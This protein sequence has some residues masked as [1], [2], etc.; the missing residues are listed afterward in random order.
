MG[1][2][3]EKQ[4]NGDYIVHTVWNKREQQ[5]NWD[6]THT[7]GNKREQQGNGDYTQWEITQKSREMRVP[8][9]SNLIDFTLRS[10]FHRF[11]C[12]SNGRF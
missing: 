8:R 5:G 2:N 4:G 11:Y 7:V 1:N 6:H 10:S 3:I 9:L 12:S